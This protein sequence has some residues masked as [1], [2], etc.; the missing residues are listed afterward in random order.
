ML[1]IQLRQSELFWKNFV[2][3][4]F[5]RIAGARKETC[6]VDVLQRRQVGDSWANDKY[7]SIL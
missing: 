4:L 6:F 7:L 5:F 3:I 2:S 1:N